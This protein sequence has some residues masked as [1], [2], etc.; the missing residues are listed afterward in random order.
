M[1]NFVL[2]LVT[3]KQ[4]RHCQ[5]NLQEIGNITYYSRDMGE[6]ENIEIESLGTV[7]AL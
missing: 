7:K 3:L 1:L 2:L 4:L 6:V 5:C